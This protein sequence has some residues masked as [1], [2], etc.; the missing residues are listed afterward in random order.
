[1][2][3][4]TPATN[5]A[6]ITAAEPAVRTRLLCPHARRLMN[7]AVLGSADARLTTASHPG[8]GDRQCVAVEE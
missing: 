7:R 2:T 8:E 1:M 5:T 4:G 3:R 6:W